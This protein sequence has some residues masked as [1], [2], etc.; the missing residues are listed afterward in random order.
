MTS[1]R[2]QGGESPTRRQGGESPTRKGESPARAASCSPLKAQ[3]HATTASRVTRSSP[4]RR[5][6][7][8][9]RSVSAAPKGDNSND[10]QPKGG[11]ASEMKID[12]DSNDQKRSETKLT[13]DQP[14]S[15]VGTSSAPHVENDPDQVDDNVVGGDGRAESWRLSS[16]EGADI[17]KSEMKNSNIHSEGERNE[18]KENA[19]PEGAETAEVTE[20]LFKDNV[21]SK[22]IEINST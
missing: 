22:S 8:P 5:K 14:S 17:S 19:L 13:D 21:E 4:T 15:A 18:D 6:A 10:S 16:S 11:D 2:R 3:G 1:P 9:A 12:N 7:S 20:T